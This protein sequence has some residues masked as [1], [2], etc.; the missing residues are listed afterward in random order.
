M[1]PGGTWNLHLL[2][3]GLTPLFRKRSVP[4]R[5][6]S[7]H[8]GPM[9][10]AI[11][12]VPALDAALFGRAAAV[13]RNRRDIRDARDLEAAGV[14]GTHSRLATRSWAAD[15]H[16]DVLHAVFLR[17]IAGLLG[18]HLRRERRGFAR[19]AKAATTRGRPGQR[20][21]LAIGDRDDGVV[22]RRVHVRDAVEHVFSCLLRL[23]R[24]TGGGGAGGATRSSSRGV[25]G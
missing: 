9:Y 16:F 19:T 11:C 17:R 24:A 12:W 7:L 5:R 13:V 22:E 2:S 3:R 10:R 18:G 8:L 25:C 20:V 4:S 14:Q 1:P 21:S 6:A 23:L 15:T